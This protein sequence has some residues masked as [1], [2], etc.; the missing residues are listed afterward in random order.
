MLPIRLLEEC[1]EQLQRMESEDKA[2]LIAGLPEDPKAKREMAKLKRKRNE[3]RS[4]TNVPW[5][6]DKKD[7][8][9][10]QQGIAAIA[11]IHSK[12]Q[13]KKPVRFSPGRGDGKAS[14]VI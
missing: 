2:R 10:A 3:L 9:A 8:H 11:P 6:W 12:R 7:D 1:E 5:Y 13:V 14:A 4:V